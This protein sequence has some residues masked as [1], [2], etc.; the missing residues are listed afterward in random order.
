MGKLDGRTVAIIATDGFELSELT[1]PKAELEREGARTEVLSLHEGTIR[2]WK[3]GNWSGE[4]RVDHLVADCISDDYDALF[5][6]GGAMNPDQL[7]LEEDVVRLVQEFFDAGKPIAA[8][9]HGPQVLIETGELEGRRLTSWPSLKTDLINAGAEWVDQEVVED[10]NLVTSRTPDDLPRFNAKLIEAFQPQPAPIVTV[11]S[12][13]AQVDE[14]ISTEPEA[15][16]PASFSP[17]RRRRPAPEALS[18]APRPPRGS[19]AASA[20]E[21]T[22]SGKNPRSKR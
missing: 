7:R 21:K 5:I 10:E 4:V 12:I 14:L 17:P 11:E 13:E 2:G 16:M 1:S 20:R 8:I 15:P 18:G 22:R 3:H 19:R 9:C 6:P